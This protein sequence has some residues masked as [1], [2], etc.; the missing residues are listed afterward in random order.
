MEIQNCELNDL[1]KML[2]KYR[3]ATEY[4][5]SKN[6]VAWPEFE[7]EMLEEEIKDS[8]QWKLQIDGEI[9]C[10]WLTALNDE[11]IWGKEN[12]EPSLYLHRIA[13]AQEFR[14]R[15]LV[16]HIVDWAD[17][18]CMDNELKYIRMD[19]GGYNE[20]LIRHYEKLGFDFLGTKEL[21]NTD[22]LPAHYSNIPICLF[23]RVPTKAIEG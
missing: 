3:V 8:R 7:R 9:A 15:N 23:Q 4:M 13:T 11:L 2:E 20:G 22:S 18:F 6:Q 17:D 19:T 21:E 1:P 14:G 16:Q 10:I 12:D 5:K